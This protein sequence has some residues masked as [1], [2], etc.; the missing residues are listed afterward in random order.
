MKT[1]EENKYYIWLSKL[2]HISVKKKYLL[3]NK[4]SPKEIYMMNRKRIDKIKY[5]SEKNKEE[6]LKNKNI[7]EVER[8]I[9][10]M[11]E[12]E[13]KLINYNDE[14]YPKQLK[15][16]SDPPIT[17]YVKGNI[18]IL[19]NKSIG[20]IGSRDFSEY[21]KKATI[22]FSTN[23]AKEG[24]NIISGL[25]KGIDS[26]AHKGALT[27]NGNTTAVIGSGI[28]I[29]YPKENIEIYEEI[30]KRNGAIISE[31]P[32]GTKPI[33]MNF[34]AR[35]RIISGMSNKILVIEA[36]KKSGTLIT[37]EFALEQGIDIYA[38]PRKYK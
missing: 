32:I 33:P 11:K 26:I 25:A 19:N 9:L 16:I 3:L 34:P 14:E 23:L 10:Y 24:F 2:I 4:Y 37:V 29:M 28:D 31:Y 12:N 22:Y 27:S 5:L 18:K 30:I 6:I 13:I 15:L 21:G 17:L 38:V 35:N 20:I 7:E 1:L 8:D 36:K